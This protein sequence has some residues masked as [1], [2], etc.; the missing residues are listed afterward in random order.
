MFF[1]MAKDVSFKEVLA[2]VVR[3]LV[4]V[5]P[6]AGAAWLL[7]DVFEAGMRWRSLFDKSS[8][9]LSLH[10]F[11]SKALATSVVAAL[12]YSGL[13]AFAAVATSCIEAWN[14]CWE[15]ILEGKDPLG[16]AKSLIRPSLALAG[17]LFAAPIVG[18]GMLVRKI[19]LIPPAVEPVS[20][21]V[22]TGLPGV[23]EPPEVKVPPT[24]PTSS[25]SSLEQRIVLP[26]TL[27]VHFDDAEP[28]T[29][30][31]DV[32]RR[33]VT[34]G[35]DRKKRLEAM[36]TMLGRSLDPKREQ[37]QMTVYGFASSAQFINAKSL[38]ES[39]RLNLL[40]ANRRADAVHDLLEGVAAKQQGLRVSKLNPWVQLKDMKDRREKIPVPA[41][42]QR[43]SFAHRVA[44][45]ELSLQP[46]ES[47]ETEE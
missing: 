45:V 25:P 8:L 41:G 11:S 2:I 30:W 34:L 14:S 42:L 6:V 23:Q 32:T 24:T 47:S 17:V 13:P 35:P 26:E 43:E 39:D 40:A 3:G 22:P 27:R 1:L 18:E 21:E 5:V 7:F 29:D 38:E 16:C 36:L 12:A 9:D 44:L 15:F 4:I 46:E 19:I 28:N 33:G 10:N 37:I 31:T 20:A